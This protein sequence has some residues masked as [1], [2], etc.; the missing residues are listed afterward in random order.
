MHKQKETEQF[1]IMKIGRWLMFFFILK[2]IVH[3]TTIKL[4]AC[5]DVWSLDSLAGEKQYFIL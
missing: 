2:R 4:H 5:P 3:I 1:W